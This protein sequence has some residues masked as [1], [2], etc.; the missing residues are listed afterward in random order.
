MK[1]FI[2]DANYKHTLGA[3]RSLGEK[4]YHIIAGASTKYAISFYSKYCAEKVIYPNP[5]NEKLFVK[6]LLDYVRNNSIDVLMPIGYLTTTILSK[7]KDEFIKYTK[8]PVADWASMEIACN[9]E[10]TMEF[11]EKIGIKVPKTY[12]CI[13]EIKSFPIVIKGIKESN[14]LSY[15]NS[16]DELL[17]S[18]IS[19]CL[20]QEYICGEGYG[21][22]AL[23]NNGNEK[24]FFMHKRI[25]EYPITGGPSTLAESVFENKLLRS[26]LKLLKALKWNGVAMVEF[27]KDK[28]DNEFKLM[29]VNPKFWGSLDLSITSGVDFPNLLIKMALEGDTESVFHYNKGIKFRWLFPDDILYLLSNPKDIKRFFHDLY[30]KDIYTNININDIKPN[31]IQFILT[32]PTI[33][34]H[35][36]NHNFKYPNGI[37]MVK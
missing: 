4:N 13:D 31:V 1:I 24:A 8:L 15:I 5:R 21:F 16:R 26:G 37:P 25:R 11:A 22:F 6:F 35:L 17:K 14:N 12:S 9:K 36:K 30:D 28:K 27:K 34:S 3:I 20:I 23:L 10:R 7:Y 18:N 2:T 33:Y 32:I 29:E 19:D